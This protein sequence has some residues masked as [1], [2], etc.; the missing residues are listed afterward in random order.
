[1]YSGRSIEMR[2]DLHKAG[3]DLLNNNMK[4]YNRAKKSLVV[5]GSVGCIY[6]QDLKSLKYICQIQI[7]RAPKFWVQA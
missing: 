1:M 4:L 5:C 2:V 7:A 3:E 6:A